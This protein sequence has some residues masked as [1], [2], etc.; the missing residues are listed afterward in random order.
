MGK[1]Q[2]LYCIISFAAGVV[3]TVGG[4]YV[5]GMVE[6]NR[7]VVTT[8]EGTPH[9]AGAA[10]PRGAGPASGTAAAVA[11]APSYDAWQASRLGDNETA[12]RAAAAQLNALLSSNKV[13][14]KLTGWTYIYAFWSKPAA[15]GRAATPDEFWTLM[16]EINLPDRI[17]EGAAS[18]NPE[19]KK[20]AEGAKATFTPWGL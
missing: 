19:I 17:T 5:A 18:S 12:H 8:P 2:A 11:P 7:Q 16:R 3:V 9:R 13:E 20:Q 6:F 1:H 14:D 10:A 4:M 15:G